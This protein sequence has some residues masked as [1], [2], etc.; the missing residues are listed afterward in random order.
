ML[1]F[2]G[3]ETE[4]QNGKVIH[5]L[6]YL[7]FYTVRKFLYVHEFFIVGNIYISEV[8]FEINP[9]FFVLYVTVDKISQ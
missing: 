1:L 2:L 7:L 9:I 3:R 6:L 5:F 8:N 4:A